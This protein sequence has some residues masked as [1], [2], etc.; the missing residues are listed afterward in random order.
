MRTRFLGGLHRALDR[1][2]V[3]SRGFANPA[4][5][6]DFLATL[7]ERN[8]GQKERNGLFASHPETQERIDKIKKDAAALKGGNAL[9]EAR[10][11]SVIKYEPSELTEVAQAEKG[12]A[13]LAGGS[14][15]KTSGTEKTA[16]K[17]AEEQPKKKGFGL[18]SLKRVVAP[19]GQT[20]QVS[21]SGGARGVGP[22]RNAKG[23]PNAAI[24]TVTLTAA[25]LAAFRKGIA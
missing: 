7:A 8:K 10:Y 3:H 11:R 14:S 21:A 23:G 15:P 13:G 20:A 24:V 12:S 2:R 18:G 16:A 9:V 4:G 1:P 22:D 6:A 5:L 19:E 25:D 17:P